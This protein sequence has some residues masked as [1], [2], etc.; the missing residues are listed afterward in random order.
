VADEKRLLLEDT[1]KDNRNL[2]HQDANLLWS[3]DNRMY[4]TNRAFV[5]YFAGNR[6]YRDTLPEP[7]PGPVGPYTG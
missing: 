1:V 4:V 3:I 2:E 6:L 7:L 5:T